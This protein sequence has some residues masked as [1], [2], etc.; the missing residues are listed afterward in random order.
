[1][2]V[3]TSSSVHVVYIPGPTSVLIFIKA[4]PGMINKLL[5]V[6]DGGNYVH[7]LDSILLYI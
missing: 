7:L 6:R 2:H 4:R 5:K 3:H 1:M